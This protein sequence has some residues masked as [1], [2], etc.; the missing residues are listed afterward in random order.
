LISQ[1][2]VE[3]S[4]TV[5][6]EPADLVAARQIVEREFA[7]EIQVGLVADSVVEEGLC[8]V[9]A[10]GEGMRERVGVSGR[11]FGVLGRHGISV[12]V[13]VQSS[14]ERSIT[15]VVA[16]GDH[17]TA[18]RAV[19]DAFFGP[20]PPP[21]EIV[22]A[23]VG[24][25]GSQLLA[26]LAEGRDQSEGRGLRLVGLADSRGTVLEWN[27]ID[28]QTWRDALGQERMPLAEGCALLQARRGRD[29]VFVDCTA[30][31]RL[32]RLYPAL[33]RSGVT[34][35]AANKR[36]FA[37]AQETYDALLAAAEEGG[38]RLFHE[39]T[40]GAGLPVLTTVADLVRTG[41]RV[42]RIEGV[43]SG[44]LNFVLDRI[45]NKT[46]LSKAVREAYE[47]GLTEPHP[48]EDLGGGDVA[49]KLCI[50][51]RGLGYRLEPARIEVQPLVE[52]SARAASDLDTFWADLHGEDVPFDALRSKAAERGERL[53]YVA[54]LDCQGEAPQ[55]VVK[56]ESI[57]ATHPCYAVLG[58]DNLV[59]MHT[60]RYDNSPIVVQGPGAGPAV[61]AAGVYADLLRATSP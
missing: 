4:I 44:T 24:Q 22:L 29:R 31:D 18:V 20:Q 47:L 14:S 16:Q 6:L 57:G 11:L 34:V 41:D 59:A 48:A 38:A 60:A 35:V 61:T 46:P 8:V 51:A 7:L 39:A 5:A 25:V 32:A 36:P 15:V 37:G 52:V 53:R 21:A 33:L 26:Q 43:L 58:S 1:S 56:V 50:L 28:T 45:D 19:H 27:G 12:R 10:V 23:G 42:T 55:A 13:T 9:T 17:D 30:S 3:G 40:V 49:R 2:S 54:R